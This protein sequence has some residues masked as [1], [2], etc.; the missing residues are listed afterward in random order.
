MSKHRVSP[1]PS[2]ALSIYATGRAEVLADWGWSSVEIAQHLGTSVQAV[3]E[4]LSDLEDGGRFDNY[5]VV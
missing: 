4:A 1:A 3:E 5:D 2:G